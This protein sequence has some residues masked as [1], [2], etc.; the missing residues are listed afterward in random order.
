MFAVFH[1]SVVT[2]SPEPSHICAGLG[3]AVIVAVHP[4]VI[5]FAVT[6]AR[7]LAAVSGS[8]PETFWR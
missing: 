5:T 7:V 2:P 6:V 4:A 8:P 3:T 1:E